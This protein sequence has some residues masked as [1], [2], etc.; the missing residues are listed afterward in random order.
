VAIIAKFLFIGLIA[1]SGCAL[2]RHTTPEGIT[3]W[4]EWV[5]EYG[6]GVKSIK[7]TEHREYHVLCR[8]GTEDW[9]MYGFQERGDNR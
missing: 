8:D 3:P 1:L 7:F 6:G 5:C 2:T 9:S 4:A